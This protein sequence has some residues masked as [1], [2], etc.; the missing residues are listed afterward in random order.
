M[1]SCSTDGVT[2]T[3]GEDNSFAFTIKQDGT[4]LPMELTPTDTFTC[5][6]V[7]N[8]LSTTVLTKQL[9]LDASLLSGKVHL[10]I[11]SAE[12]DLL[13]SE[14]GSKVDRYY[15]KPVYEIR[16]ICNTTNNGDFI[17]SIKNV[18]VS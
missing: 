5:K 4:T 15:L 18:Y 8:E 11:T 9:T 14:R 13:V 16:L 7:N 2:I 10:V 6:V 1:A 17:A 12:T 3:K